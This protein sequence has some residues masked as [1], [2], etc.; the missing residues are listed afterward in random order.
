MEKILS[1]IV[2]YWIVIT[3]LDFFDNP[4]EKEGNKKNPAVDSEANAIDSRTPLEQILDA[5]NKLQEEH[6]EEPR[7][8][9][10][11]HDTSSEELKDHTEKVWERLGYRVIDGE[12]Y[13]YKM[14]GNEIYTPDQVEKVSAQHGYSQSET[15]GL[16]YIL[17]D[18]GIEHIYHITHYQNLE[19]ILE[20]G[21]LS[22][23]NDL[24]NERIDNAEVNDRR[25]KTETINYKNLHD[26]VPF[27][28]NPKNPMLF[29]NKEIQEDIIIL[30]FNRKLLLKEKTI[31]TDGNAAVNTTKYFNE[32]DE[33]DELNWGCIKS[34]YWNDYHD[35]KREVMAEVLFPKKV[36]TKHL[37]K[38]YCYDKATQEYAMNLDEGIDVEVNKKLY[39]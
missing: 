36:S 15:K 34:R 8:T 2:L 10:N 30:A 27:Y 28:F 16:K 14:Y 9:N 11:H 39:F 37:Q 23:N 24:V 29:V 33:L 19:S 1:L 26:Y 22:H 3:V 32:L 35:G 13:T 20:N 31:F 38:I 7:V 17:D 6:D 21:L 5:G 12:I 4:K 25:N 18:Y